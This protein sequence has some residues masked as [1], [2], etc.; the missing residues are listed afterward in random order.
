MCASVVC[1]YA[2]GTNRVSSPSPTSIMSPGIALLCAIMAE[3]TATNS[4]YSSRISYAVW[5]K[6]SSTVSRTVS[7][8]ATVSHKGS[9]R[10]ALSDLLP[11]CV[12]C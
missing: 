12:L 6:Q 7:T 1:R 3:R 2:V 10:H 8:V 4:R 5:A 9:N 11:A